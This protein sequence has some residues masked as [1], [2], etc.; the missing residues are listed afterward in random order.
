[1]VLTL[2]D[3]VHPNVSEPALLDY[4]F[5]SKPAL[6]GKHTRTNRPGNRFAVEFGF[7]SV[8]S[9]IHGAQLKS[10]IIA[11]KTEPLRLPVIQGALPLTATGEP[12]VNGISVTG[13]TI[14]M[15]GFHPNT[16]IREGRLFTVE[17]GDDACLHMVRHEVIADANGNASVTIHPPLRVILDDGDRCEF[18]APY[19]VGIIEGERIGWRD[20]LDRLLDVDGFTL[21]EET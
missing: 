3:W 17:R 13:T 7:P 12:V 4:G 8:P 19:M 15:R 1:M 21:V 20:R 11:A 14:P 2:P 5:W 16:V 18:S 10:R 6:G 9:D